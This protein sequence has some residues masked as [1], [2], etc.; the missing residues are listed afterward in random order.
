M[1]LPISVTDSR[2]SPDDQIRHAAKV[3]GSS[4]H[5]AAVFHEIYRG[6]KKIKTVED[7]HQET[8]LPRVRVLQEAKKLASNHVVTQT[9]FNGDTAYQKDPFYNEHKKKI[10]KL[11]ENPQK[12]A[13]YPTK[14]T[15]R[16]IGGALEVIS[17]P[18]QRI[19][20]N[21]ITIDD[22]DSFSKVRRVSDQIPLLPPMLEKKFKRGIK[23]ILGER[24]KFTDWGGERNDLYTTRLKLAGKRRA[25][26]FAFKGRA[27]RGKLTPASMGKNADQIQR[28]FMSSAEVFLIQAWNQIDESVLHQME[29]FAK[30]N[31]IHNAKT[32]WFGVIDGQDSGRLVRAYPGKFH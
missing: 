9:K 3:I 19:N 8:K 22:I 23:R 21:Q 7:I 15:P 20:I 1:S 32:V 13:K 10:L 16:P 2:S 31:S 12:L 28:L 30:I 11:A 27:C 25:A 6:K 14:V 5:R 4:Q 26:A 29:Q 18:R 24:G 17:I